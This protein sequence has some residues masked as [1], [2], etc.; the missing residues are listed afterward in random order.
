[1]K[2]WVA[3]VLLR[4]Y[5]PLILQA[6]RI[7]DQFA[8]MAGLDFLSLVLL[9]YDVLLHSL[10]NYLVVILIALSFLAGMVAVL[11]LLLPL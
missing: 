4:E 6:L 1:M 9:R 8:N 2:L 11:G 7:V 5:L 3:K 10:I